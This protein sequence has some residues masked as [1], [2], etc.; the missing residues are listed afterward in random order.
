MGTDAW[1]LDRPYPLI[2]GEWRDPS[3][4]WPAHYAGAEHAYCHLEKL[5]NLAALPAVGATLLC[6]P[7][8]VEGGSGA[9]VRAVGLVPLDT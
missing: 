8:K 6:M 2:G 1:S 7:I 4:L 3:L 9:W 5:T